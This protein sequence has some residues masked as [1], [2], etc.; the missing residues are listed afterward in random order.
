MKNATEDHIIHLLDTVKPPI[1]RHLLNILIEQSEECP[2]SIQVGESLLKNMDKHFWVYQEHQQ[3]FSLQPIE[4]LRVAFRARIKPDHNKNP[5]QFFRLCSS[6]EKSYDRK[7]DYLKRQ[8]D[9]LQS[10]YFAQSRYLSRRT[11]FGILLS[12]LLLEALSGYAKKK[13]GYLNLVVEPALI[14]FFQFSQIWASNKKVL[15]NVREAIL[16]FPFH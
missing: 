4:T 7:K 6:P 10:K 1:R 13:K 14:V 15:A 2:V 5:V 12:E 8:F 3:V 11:S 9:Y 16:K